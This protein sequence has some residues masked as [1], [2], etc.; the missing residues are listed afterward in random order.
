MLPT[1]KEIR[2]LSKTKR[3]GY[4]YVLD[5]FAN[6]IV[7]LSIFL[8]ISP[9]ELSFFWVIVQFFSCLLFLKGDYYYSLL[10]IIIFQFM[11]IVDLSDGK[12]FRFYNSR[13]KH[14]KPL[15]PKYLDKIGHYINNPFIFLSL[16]IGLIFR[17][18]NHSY[19][20]FSLA[21]VFFYLLNKALTLNPI[22]YKSS[23]ERESII[24]ISKSPHIRESKS[25]VKKFIFDFIRIEHLGNLLF[26]LI[27][28]DLPHYAVIFYSFIYFFELIRNII[29][30]CKILIKKDKQRKEIILK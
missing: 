26:I 27:L 15:F 13:K 23:E 2:Q 24:A 16:G 19:F 11:F 9:T 1:I 5:Y 8:K 3:Y 28:F 14:L 29:F 6:Y 22:W 30:Q 17:F 10:G 7:K 18:E 4:E 21:A 12:L 25:L 20:Y